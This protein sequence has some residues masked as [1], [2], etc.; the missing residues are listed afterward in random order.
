MLL[1]TCIPSPVGCL[2]RSSVHFQI[3]LFVFLLLSFEGS[4]HILETSP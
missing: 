3:S 4:L 1:V 2:L